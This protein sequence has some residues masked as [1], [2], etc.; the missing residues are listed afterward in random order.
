VQSGGGVFRVSDEVSA[1]LLV[2]MVAP[3]LGLLRKSAGGLAVLSIEVN[4][5]GVPQNVRVVQ[6][7]ETGLDATAVEAV[8]R[9]RFEPGMKDGKPVTV[10]TVL[11][12]IF[13]AQ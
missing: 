13:P 7:L 11:A 1:P 4:G 12:V 10:G 9:W 8:K 3:Q 6:S 5:E 2:S